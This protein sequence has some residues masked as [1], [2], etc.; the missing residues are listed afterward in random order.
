LSSLRAALVVLTCRIPA[1]NNSLNRL[2][3]PFLLPS[4]LLYR[5]RLPHRPIKVTRGVTRKEAVVVL[6]EARVRPEHFSYI[7][8]IDIS[9]R[10]STTAGG[11]HA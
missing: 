3:S 7:I 9:Y 1:Q 6:L 4:W 8:D 11:S 10:L 5:L 2:A